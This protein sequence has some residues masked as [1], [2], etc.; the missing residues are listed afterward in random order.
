MKYK[1]PA[2]LLMSSLLFACSDKSPPVEQSK[3]SGT[4]VAEGEEIPRSM[5]EKANY[6]LIKREPD[7]GY[8]K[9]LHS[10]I[11]S[12]SHG[13]SVTRI[14]CSSNR[15][16]DLGY[17][18]DHKNNIKMYEHVQWTEV[19]SGSSKADLVSFVCSGKQQ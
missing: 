9:T 8:V 7:D 1:I 18:D 6:Y 3:E 13:Y 19:V 11:S 4:P 5:N 17:G 16:Q 15:Y 10:R 12:S 2:L 14:D